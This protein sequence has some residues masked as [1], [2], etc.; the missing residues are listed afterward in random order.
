MRESYALNTQIHDPDT[1]T[2]MEAV[3]GKNSEEYYKLMDDEIQ[4]LMRRDTW[5]IVSRKSI[6]NHNVLPVTWSFKCKRK[7]DWKTRKFKARYF[8][9]GD[10]QKRLSPKTLNS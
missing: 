7:P 10:I 3:S 8:V 2:Y 4:S 5:E 6:A 9:R 1:P